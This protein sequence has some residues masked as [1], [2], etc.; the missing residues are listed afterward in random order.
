LRRHDKEIYNTFALEEYFTAYPKNQITALPLHT[1]DTAPLNEYGN[2]FREASHRYRAENGWRCENCRIDLS[3]PSYHKY[4]HTHHINAQRY[5]DRR[6]NHKAL[7]IHCHAEEPMH[8]HIKN[9][10]DYQEF[11]RIYFHLLHKV[12]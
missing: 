7:C 12:A 6:D 3:H 9:S 8:S 4:V 10:P 1:D 5:D 11:M 2:G